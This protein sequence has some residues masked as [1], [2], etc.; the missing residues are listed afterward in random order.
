MP[1]NK[2]LQYYDQLAKDYDDD[3]FGNSYGNFIHQQETRLLKKILK[4]IDGNIADLGCGTGRLTSFAT[5]GVDGSSA[6]LAIAK[7]KYPDKNFYCTDIEQLPFDSNS[8]DAVYS[9]HV[10]MHLDKEKAAAVFNEASRVLKPGGL[11]IFDFP[12]ARRRNIFKSGTSGWHGNTAYSIGEIKKM[13]APKFVYLDNYGILFMPV[14]RFPKGI[15]KYFSG[16]DN[17]LCS[18][19]TNYASYNLA[20]FS[21]PL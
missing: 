6:M 4:D 21:K 14:H 9:F 20:I 15:R 8:L 16:L 1:D 3:R 17:L 7:Q 18:C 2:I 13:L 10:I 11:L 5:V 12:S 19:C